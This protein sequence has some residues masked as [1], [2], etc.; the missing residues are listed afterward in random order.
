MSQ[1]RGPLV[2]L[3]DFIK[4]ILGKTFKKERVPSETTFKKTYGLLKFIFKRSYGLSRRTEA[5]AIRKHNKLI[6]QFI[7][8]HKRGPT[9][10]EV[11]RI[12]INASHITIRYR[13]GRSGH[14]GRQKVRHYLFNLHGIRYKKK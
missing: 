14:W 2:Y 7:K 12:I 3:I 10:S 1:S 6:H 11:G 8:K 9:E 13:K 4:R 5:K